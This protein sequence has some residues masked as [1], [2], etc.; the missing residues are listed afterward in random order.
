MPHELDILEHADT[1]VPPLAGKIATGV[2]IGGGATAG[3]GQWIMANDPIAL[4]GLAVAIAGLF[5]NW[6]YRVRQLHVVQT[7]KAERSAREIAAAEAHERRQAELHAATMRQFEG[8]SH[9]R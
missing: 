5:V 1:L 2:T 4:A 8:G 6:L 7:M 3:L 9:V